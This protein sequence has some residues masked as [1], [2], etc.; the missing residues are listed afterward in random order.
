MN[1]INTGTA[2]PTRIDEDGS[3]KEEVVMGEDGQPVVES[4]IIG[5]ST[6]IGNDLVCLVDA[7]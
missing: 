4:S 3:V 7:H 5:V 6:K 2:G 1:L